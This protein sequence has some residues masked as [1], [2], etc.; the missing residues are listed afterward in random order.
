MSDKLYL[1]LAQE[2]IDYRK[3]YKLEFSHKD[4][5]LVYYFSMIDMLQRNHFLADYQYKFLIDCL[6]DELEN[7]YT[8]SNYTFHI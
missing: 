8:D 7:L 5:K 1:T 6:F 3:E 2:I 4:R